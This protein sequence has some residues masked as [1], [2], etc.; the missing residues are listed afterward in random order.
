MKHLDGAPLIFRPTSNRV[1]PAIVLGLAVILAALLAPA[2]RADAQ[3][4][5]AQPGG[6]QTTA[7]ARAAPSLAPVLKKITPAVVSIETKFRAPQDTRNRRRDARD[8]PGNVGSG[9]VFD[10][11]RGLIIT[12]NH[13]IDRADD[14]TVT[15]TD[16]RMFKAKRVGIDPDFDLAVLSVDAD[17]LPAIP[18]GDSR[19][20]EVG[21]F[22]L[23]IGYPANIGQSV[24][25]GIVSGM[26][27]TNVGVEEFENFIQTD[28]AIY[29][30]NSGG[31]LVDL[32]GDLV[33]INTAFIGA[34][35]TNPGMGFAIPVN[36]AR[37]VATQIME[38][39]EI[40]R[41]TLGI[42]IDDPTPD[43]IRELKMSA[44]QGC[45]VIVK[46]DPRSPGARAGLKSGDIVTEIGDRPVRDSTFLRTRLALLLV[47]DVAE[48]AV[49]R[50]GKP[51][52]IQAT[53]AE[54][55][56]RGRAK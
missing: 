55:D 53:V 26:H 49:L 7:P 6:A 44:P 14:I 45:A 42:T 40:R 29:P 32:Q 9:V 30:G 38:G 43:V 25:S 21:D 22:V 10:A 3:Q 54:R 15:L 20:L 1:L 28:A 47:G 50:D 51:L 16:G 27:R 17:N 31:A 4:T 18:F 8:A 36:I 34:T 56:Q 35:N 5:R 33:G 46:V 24:T 11:K 37:T 23:A 12:N 19:E 39:G 48:F 52:K 13:V 2:E 41:G